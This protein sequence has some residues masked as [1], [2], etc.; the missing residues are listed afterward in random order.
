MVVNS[1]MRI[2]KVAVEAALN[3]LQEFN[4][5]SQKLQVGEGRTKDARLIESAGKSDDLRCVASYPRSAA[6]TYGDRL[7][8]LS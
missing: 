2:E 8:K 4:R 6:G 7:P 3:S 1:L 5:V